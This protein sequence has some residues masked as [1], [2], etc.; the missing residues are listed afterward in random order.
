MESERVVVRGRGGKSFQH[1]Q[2][3]EKVKNT[4]VVRD[5]SQRYVIHCTDVLS[6][7]KVKVS[8]DKTRQ[9]ISVFIT[10]INK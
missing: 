5:L 8:I 2:M 7:R 6:R 9:Q 3:N 1:Y 10:K 4:D